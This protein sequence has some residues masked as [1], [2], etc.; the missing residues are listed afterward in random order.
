M[1]T[2]TIDSGYASE[3]LETAKNVEIHAAVESVNIDTKGLSQYQ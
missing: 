2:V 3:D 1:I